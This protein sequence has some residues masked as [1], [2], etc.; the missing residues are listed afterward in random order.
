PPI[1]TWE[2]EPKDGNR[3]IAAARF[4][5]HSSEFSVD[6]KERARWVKVWQAPEGTTEDQFEAIVVAL[7]FED[8][9]KEE[10]PE[11]VKARLGHQRYQELREGIPGQVTT[12][13]D[14]ELKRKVSNTFAIT[15]AE[16]TRY[17]RMVQWAEEF[18]TF[19]TE[20][21]ATDPAEVRY[22]AN[23]I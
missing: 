20:E 6:Q 5:L 7:N 11:Y 9:H 12:S 16:V 22:R 8:D 18:E 21:R 2:G 3:R 10:W 14:R 15:P 1:L 19:H 17:I 23:D 4:V 13:A